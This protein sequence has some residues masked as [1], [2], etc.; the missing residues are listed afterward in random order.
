MTPIEKKEIAAHFIESFNLENLHN[1]DAAK[2]LNL[3]LC[4]I[5]WIKNE[6]CHDS[7]SKAAW[8]RF[9]QWHISRGKI[10]DFKIPEGEPLLEIT[11]PE[12]VLYPVRPE[13]DEHSPENLQPDKQK[14]KYTRHNQGEGKSVK[15]VLQKQEI[16]ELNKRIDI[17]I[18]DNNKLSRTC[19]DL[20]KKVFVIE[21]LI[22]EPT[23]KTG[24]QIVIFQRNIYRKS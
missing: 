23:D 12:P 24:H 17:L 9:E 3:K 20:S 4:Y 18:E 8:E 2:L 16:K 19:E 5:S 1:R 11:R 21:D 13:T 15:I 22:K 14:R 10:S 6:N 7:I